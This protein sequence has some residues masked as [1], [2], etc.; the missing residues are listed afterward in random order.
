LDGGRGNSRRIKEK[1]PAVGRLKPCMKKGVGG[2]GSK[3]GE[4]RACLGK[5]RREIFHRKRE[6]SGWGGRTGKCVG[7]KRL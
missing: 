7:N 1:N 2:K 3:G 6:K 4:R 5:H